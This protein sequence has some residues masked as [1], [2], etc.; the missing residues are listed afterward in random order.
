MMT[1]PRQVQSNLTIIITD[2][3]EQRRGECITGTN[4]PI[5]CKGDPIDVIS[6]VTTVRRGSAELLLKHLYPC[7][8]N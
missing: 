1:C 6:E 5:L 7:E 2:G 3:T 8:L 4:V